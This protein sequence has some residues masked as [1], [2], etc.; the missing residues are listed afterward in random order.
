MT[1]STPPGLPLERAVDGLASFLRARLAERAADPAVP[2]ETREVFARQRSDISRI[3]AHAHSTGPL[4]QIHALRLLRDMSLLWYSHD[5]HPDTPW[6]EQLTTMDPN[7]ALRH[8]Q[9]VQQH[10]AGRMGD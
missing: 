10:Q 2:T 9:D 8:L 1:T 7:A 3:A 6:L 5:D 4:Q